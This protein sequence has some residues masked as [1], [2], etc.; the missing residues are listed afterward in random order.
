M[1]LVTVQVQYSKITAFYVNMMCVYIYIYI[2][3]YTYICV[4][5][6]VCDPGAQKQSEVAGVYL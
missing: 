1:Q 2:Y 5:V 4:C 3:I 6:C